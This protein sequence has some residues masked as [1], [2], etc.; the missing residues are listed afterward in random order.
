MVTTFLG[1]SVAILAALG[2]RW[3]AQN[4]TRK[5]ASRRRKQLA[6]ALG[7]RLEFNLDIAKQAT[8]LSDQG[9][10]TGS[11]VD[12]SLLEA[13]R[14]LKYEVIGDIKLSQ[15]IDE[16]G[17]HLTSLNRLIDLGFEIG[18]SGSFIAISG[19]HEL[20]ARLHALIRDQ[21]SEAL[22]F[23]RGNEVVLRLMDIVGPTSRAEILQE[24]RRVIVRRRASR[25]KVRM[26]VTR[27]ASPDPAS[28]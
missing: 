16:L 5:A 27:Q 9:V 18:Y 21:A 1:A 10:L 24:R 7:K 22:E 14:S 6:Q 26:R 3:L 11:N 12:L 13:T 19:S 23:E 2:L 17:H 20:R 25:R 28:L 8:G 15:D 4:E